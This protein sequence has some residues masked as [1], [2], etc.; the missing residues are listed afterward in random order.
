MPDY[1]ILQQNKPIGTLTVTQEGL[2]TV[3]SARA[4]TDADRLRLAVCG[5]RSRAYLGLMLRTGAAGSR[6]AGG[7][8]GSSAR[9]CRSRSCLRPTRHGTFRTR[10]PRPRTRRRRKRLRRTTDLTCSGIL[11][12]TGYSPRLTASGCSL[13][14]RRTRRTCRA[15]PRP[16]CARSTAGR[17]SFFRAELQFRRRRGILMARKRQRS[18]SR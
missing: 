14:F 10:R 2:F 15:A 17:T 8:R 1:P 6:C 18:I 16:C 9:A 4:K 7:S 5:E 13:P 3:F 11:R 12:R